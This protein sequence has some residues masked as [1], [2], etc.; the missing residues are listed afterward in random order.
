M[1]YNQ[2]F[3]AARWWSTTTDPEFSV[4]R[5]SGGRRVVSL[6][7]A[8][9]DA[10]LNEILDVVLNAILDAVFDAVLNAVFDAVVLDAVVDV[11]VQVPVTQ[12]V[13]TPLFVGN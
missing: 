4:E 9:L 3:V 13:D 1:I 2:D 7:D 10:V 6:R 12:H 8:I 11:A 5:S